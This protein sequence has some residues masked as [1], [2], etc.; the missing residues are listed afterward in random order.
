[1]VSAQMAGLPDWMAVLATAL[2]TT[3]LRVLAIASDWR[4]P[5]WRASGPP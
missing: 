3:A 5:A 4:L 1:M 2:V